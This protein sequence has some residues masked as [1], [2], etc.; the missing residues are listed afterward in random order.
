[1]GALKGWFQCLRGLRVNVFNNHD[2]KEACRWITITIILHNLIIDVEGPDSAAEFV[3]SHTAA[4]ELKMQATMIL[5]KK[6]K[7]SIKQKTWEKPNG[8]D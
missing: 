8:V 7:S 4:D 6:K 5:I 1:M 2:H 3:A